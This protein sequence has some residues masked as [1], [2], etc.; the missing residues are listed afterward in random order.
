MSK[1]IYQAHNNPE[2]APPPG[3]GMV[4]Y[5]KFNKN[6]KKIAPST[7]VPEEQVD[8][9]WSQHS[10]G[11][12][13]IGNTKNKKY[14]KLSRFIKEENDR[15]MKIHNMHKEYLEKK[16]E[17]KKLENKSE[18]KL[19][20][21]LTYKAIKMSDYLINKI[22]QVQHDKNNVYEKR[23]LTLLSHKK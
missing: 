11:Q 3:V 7:V 18:N 16:L 17:E 20:N 19:K 8:M 15:I 10:Y 23:T 2:Y 13:G 21:K 5:R 1:T 4:G 6:Y 22:D 14:N 12:L 9:N